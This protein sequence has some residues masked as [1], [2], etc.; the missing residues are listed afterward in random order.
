MA[1]LI[2]AAGLAAVALV[3][4][5]PRAARA[6][7]SAIGDTGAAVARGALH[8]HSNRSDGTGTLDEIAAAAAAAG[9]QFV[10]VTDHGNGTREPEPPAYRA[11][12]LCLDGVEISTRQGHLVALGLGRTPYPL[13]GEPR[14]V[15]EDVHRFGGMAI[16]A[17]PGS[18]KACAALG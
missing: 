13:A 2:L 14:D 1:V 9:L 4:L 16:A 18:P 6:V 12:V 3:L 7:A 15:I 10:I 5:P 11:G 17:H 8:V